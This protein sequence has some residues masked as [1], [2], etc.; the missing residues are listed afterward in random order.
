VHY[1]RAVAITLKSASTTRKTR[2]PHILSFSLPRL[3]VSVS[4]LRLARDLRRL[5]VYFWTI[6]TDELSGEPFPFQNA[7][8]E[9]VERDRKLQVA[10][11]VTASDERPMMEHPIGGRPNQSFR[12]NR[13]ISYPFDA[14][15]PAPLWTVAAPGSA[16]VHPTPAGEYTVVH[17]RRP[18]PLI[19]IKRI[20]F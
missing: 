2:A 13:G 18:F 5:G 7:L 16:S 4:H 12:N 15:P 3:G 9:R 14:L 17:Y 1:T 11:Q 8:P 10:F 19:F 20:R 6:T